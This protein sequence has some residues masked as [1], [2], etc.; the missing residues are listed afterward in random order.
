ME[1]S[2]LEVKLGKC[3]RTMEL[4]Q[5]NQIIVLIVQIIILFKI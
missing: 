1:K 3:N 4:I 2:K 5:I